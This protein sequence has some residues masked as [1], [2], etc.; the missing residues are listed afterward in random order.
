M[1]ELRRWNRLSWAVDIALVVAVIIAGLLR[2]LNR[3]PGMRDPQL[4]EPRPYLLDLPWSWLV[5]AHVAGALLLLL[6]R[7]KPRLMGALLTLL[8]CAVPVLAAAIAPYSIARYTIR[9]RDAI[10][11]NALLLLALWTGGRLWPLLWSPDYS[12]GDAYTPALVVALLTVTGLYLRARNDL[13]QAH[14]ER[15]VLLERAGLAMRL[16]DDIARDLTNA[17]LL[18]GVMSVEARDDTVRRDAEQVR[19]HGQRALAQAAAMI[20]WL[21]STDAHPDT[22]VDSGTVESGTVE[23]GTD[24]NAVTRDR[25]GSPTWLSPADAVLVDHVTDAAVSNAELHAPGQPILITERFDRDG[26]A[27]VRVWN[28]LGPISV[29]HG[30]DVGLGLGLSIL[31]RRCAWQGAQFIH[32]PTDDDGFEVSL[33]VERR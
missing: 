27:Q 12:Q 26:S 24:T 32:G 4:A 1:R 3:Q 14:A 15:A 22:G 18:A 6:R 23:S 28:H 25:T 7:H 29:H 5:L 30:L 20:R 17:V 13:L 16:H 9:V 33:R 2:D 21:T 10:L 11:I 8:A 31:E 19:L